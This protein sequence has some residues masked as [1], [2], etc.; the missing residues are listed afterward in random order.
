MTT[1]NQTVSRIFHL[2]HHLANGGQTTNLS[3]LE[4]D[5]DINRIT[6]SR[7]LASLVVDK[8]IEKKTEGGHQLSLNFL[9]LMVNSL[10][11]KDFTDYYQNRLEALS[12]QF[13]LSAYYTVLDGNNVFYLG[14]KTP[15][16]PLISNI[17]PGARVPF[18]TVAPGIILWAHQTESKRQD[19]L[20]QAHKDWPQQKTLIDQ[21][22]VQLE[23]LL[24]EKCAWSFSG[25]DNKVNACAAAIVTTTQ[26]CIAAISLAGPEQNFLDTSEFKEELSNQLLQ[27]CQQLGLIYSQVG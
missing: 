14:R 13:S 11:S 15:S 21:L 7:L 3:Q 10:N 9:A 6:L 26:Q 8:V 20:S 24:K 12:Q 22:P 18:F 16:T 27:T 25:Y 17:K 1:T 2:I 5:L 23:S 19:M 4:R